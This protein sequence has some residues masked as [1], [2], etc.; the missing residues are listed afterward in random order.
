MP[1][2]GY[3]W[4]ARCNLW[5]LPVTGYDRLTAG[6]GEMRWRLAGMIPVMSGSGR[7]VTRSA[8]GRLASE[9]VLL[10]TT[11]GQATW[12]EGDGAV[13]LGDLEDRFGAGMCPSCT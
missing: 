5:G 11:F 2:A 13:A 8:W 1:S 6:T 9:G 10:P 12:A 3:I 7:D 4:A